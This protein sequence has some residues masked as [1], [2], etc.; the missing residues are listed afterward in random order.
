MQLSIHQ[1]KTC[2]Y[3]FISPLN[4]TTYGYAFHVIKHLQRPRGVEAIHFVINS[5]NSF[6]DHPGTWFIEEC[7]VFIKIEFYEPV[8]TAK[9]YFVESAFIF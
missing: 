3:R 8:D 4:L 9:I 7:F 1:F 6:F 2:R 5:T